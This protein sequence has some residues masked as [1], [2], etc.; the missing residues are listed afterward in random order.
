M[1]TSRLLSFAAAILVTSVQL[2]ALAALFIAAPVHNDTPY[3]QS[4]F[5]QSPASLPALLVVAS[6]TD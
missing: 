5:E 3:Q 2:G 1:K 6:R 4:Q